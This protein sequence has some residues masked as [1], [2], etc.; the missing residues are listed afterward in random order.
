[1]FGN[2]HSP[3][4]SCD[5]PFAASMIAGFPGPAVDEDITSK[6]RCHWW[7]FLCF[8]S[9]GE[10]GE[11]PATA[12]GA[13]EA[14]ARC[15]LAALNVDRRDLVLEE[16]LLSREHFK[17]TRH[18]AFV[19][20]VGE[21]EGALRRVDGALLDDG[22]LLEDAEGGELVFNVVEGLEDSVAVA[23]GL[24]LVI[25]A[26]LV[27]ERVALAGVKEQLRGLAAEGPDG[28]GALNQGAEARALK[29]A[30]GAESDGGVVGADGDADLRVGCGGLALDGGD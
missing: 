3:E 30:G 13:D 28:A 15:E 8:L 2:E 23:I 24:R 14:H 4:F 10:L 1:M 12:E 22:L 7:P 20:P 26:G 21:F 5:G 18:A 17:I 25:V 11:V 16:R 19:A 9:P 27:G 6:G 29:A